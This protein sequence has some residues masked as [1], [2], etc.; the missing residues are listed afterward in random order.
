MNSSL[1]QSII[2]VSNDLNNL[3]CNLNPVY[4]LNIKHGNIRTQCFRQVFIRHDKLY[5]L[6]E[7]IKDDDVGF[8]KNF[9]SYRHVARN[10]T[11]SNLLLY[12]AIIAVSLKSQNVFTELCSNI[13]LELDVI[14]K[15]LGK[16]SETFT[17]YLE[18]LAYTVICSNDPAIYKSFFLNLSKCKEGLEAIRRASALSILTYHIYNYESHSSD[19]CYKI[20]KYFINAMSSNEC[21]TFI[22]CV[23][24][25]H[26]LA[27][28]K[29]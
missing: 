15:L 27:T 5:D 23:E 25:L 9:L 2:A 13:V 10:I 28:C 22:N 6:V 16:R 29:K 26:W 11:P 19:I 20:M 7:A 8:V 12:L 18:L 14:T 21:D 3:L 4:E 1:E 24:F 17:K